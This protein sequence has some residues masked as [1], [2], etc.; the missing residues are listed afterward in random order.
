MGVIFSIGDIGMD[1][2]GINGKVTENSC[3]IVYAIRRSE[4]IATRKAK[5]ATFSIPTKLPLE[6]SPCAGRLEI[7]RETGQ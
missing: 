6:R 4:E 2:V 1:D 3:C 7:R 5:F